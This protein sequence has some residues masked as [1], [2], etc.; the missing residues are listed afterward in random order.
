[1]LYQRLL[2]NH[3]SEWAL[4]SEQ[5]FSLWPALRIS[6][7]TRNPHI[8]GWLLQVA[9]AI[10]SIQPL[11]QHR[12]HMK[13]DKFTDT[14]LPG[15]LYAKDGATICLYSA[16]D[17]SR[18]CR[19]LQHVQN[20]RPPVRI[21]RNFCRWPL[22]VGLPAYMHTYMHACMHTIQYHTIPYHTI[23]TIP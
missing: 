2:C 9:P 4:S 14:N 17:P 12:Q 15:R 5:N 20:F 13:L 19:I 8:K 1:M 22:P 7:T 23:H 18:L 10:Q 21:F 11:W 16:S 3:Y 6:D